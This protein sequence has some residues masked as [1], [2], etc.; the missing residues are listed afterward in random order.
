MSRNEVV[1]FYKI[2]TTKLVC[3]PISFTVP[4]K[5][6]LFQSD[7]FPDTAGDEPALSIEEW[8]SGKD[9]E[10]I[11]ISLEGGFQAKE[12]VASTIGTK[13]VMAGLSSKKIS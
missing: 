4:R 6:E 7:I 2:H 13:N 5:S 8:I 1:R 3:E 10:P 11:M 12:K 9:A